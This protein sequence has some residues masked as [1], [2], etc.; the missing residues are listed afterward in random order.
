M[1]DIGLGDESVSIV[2][3]GGG[4]HALAALAALHDDS[5]PGSLLKVGTGTLMHA[6]GL[7]PSKL[8]P[9]PDD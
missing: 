5:R 2:I 6:V 7:A 4:P 9:T 1:D 3:V 8:R